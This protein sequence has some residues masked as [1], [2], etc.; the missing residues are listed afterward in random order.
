VT[1]DPKKFFGDAN[2][3]GKSL[4]G[5]LN[6][7]KNSI[8]KVGDAVLVTPFKWLSEAIN[9]VPTPLAAVIAGMAAL[10]ILGQVSSFLWGGIAAWKGFGLAIS[11]VSRALGTSLFLN[12]GLIVESLGGATDGFLALGAAIEA[13][14]VGWIL[15]G[16]AA[17]AAALL[18]IYEM[19][20]H[21]D[22]MVK[23]LPQGGSINQFTGAYVGPDG[24][25]AGAGG[26]GGLSGLWSHWSELWNGPA[27]QS[28]T[29]PAPAPRSELK[30]PSSPSRL[31]A[32][33]GASPSSASGSAN[34]QVNGQVVVTFENAP[35]NLTTRKV[36]SDN[37]NV[38]LDVNMGYGMMAVPF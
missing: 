30:P 22:D 6:L 31:P 16:L 7:L 4:T 36:Q 25:I 11:A 2:E 3:A 37:P 21:R 23:A 14:P 19:A 35:P 15:T 12:L 27:Q 26:L 38:D 10:S 20:K 29:S 13:T 28:D 32:F 18:G 24:S 17:I 33:G 9:L 34:N 8:D 5:S 1:G